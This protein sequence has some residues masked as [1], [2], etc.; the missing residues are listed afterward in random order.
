MRPSA[1]TAAEWGLPQPPP[2]ATAEQRRQRVQ[3][4]LADL[5]QLVGQWTDSERQESYSNSST[6]AKVAHRRIMRRAAQQAP[7]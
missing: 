7:P 1:A 2:V 6:L 3:A 5:E 4:Q